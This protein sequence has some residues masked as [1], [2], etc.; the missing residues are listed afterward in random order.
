MKAVKKSV[1]EKLENSAVKL[2][3]T[4]DGTQTRVVYNRLLAKYA[5][6]A[7][8]PGFRKGHV[9]SSLLEKKFGSS[10][11]AEAFYN[12][13]EESVKEALDEVKE[14]PL[15][16]TTPKLLDEE[17]LKP[18]LDEDFTFSIQ[19]DT[20]PEI[21][22]GNYEGV[23]VE[24]PDASITDEDL[25]D[26]LKRI[27]EQNAMMIDKSEGKIEK[28]DSV[29]MNYCE[30]DE[31]GKVVESTKGEGFTFTVGNFYSPYQVDEEVV[32]MTKEE[33]KVF[34]KDYSDDE[35]DE[36][37]KG[38]KGVRIQVQIKSIKRKEIPA[39][40]DELAQDVS[41]KFKTLDDLKADAKKRLNEQLEARQKELTINAIIEKIVENSQMEIPESMIQAELDNQLHHMAHQMGMQPQQ[42]KAIFEGNPESLKEMTD[43][44]RPS[45]IKNLKQSMILNEIIDKEKI[46]V[47]DSDVEAEY[48]KM[49]EQTGRPASEIK[50]YYLAN[51]AQIYLKSDIQSRK[52]MELLISK[53][54]VKKGKKSS[55]M[56]VMKK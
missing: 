30:L 38:R 26:E 29:T 23:E 33:I 42:M 14:K 6:E 28:G 2:T 4:V 11:V 43:E 36:K 50:E 18:L 13:L 27:Q 8:M 39:L 10:L 48:Q 16:T 40:D 20:F 56:D 12:L 32:G 1:I 51:K 17:S 47:T 31:A 22:L 37:L 45:A 44:W 55:F 34:T 35:K 54:V 15:H 3:I 21:Q 52:A 49:E 46:E 7:V 9:P 5:K 41:E 24:I 25:N 19:Y 53:A